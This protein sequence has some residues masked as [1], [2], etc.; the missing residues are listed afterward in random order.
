MFLAVF[1]SPTVG[2][3]F[4]EDSVFSSG[5]LLP[6][7]PFCAPRAQTIAQTALETLQHLYTQ[8]NYGPAGIWRASIDQIIKSKLGSETSHLVSYTRIK[9]KL[10]MEWEDIVFQK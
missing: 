2:P 8:N 5:E 6:G 1:F 9:I 10:V 7:E 3:R 4:A